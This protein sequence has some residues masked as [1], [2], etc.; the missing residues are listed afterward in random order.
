MDLGIV[1]AGK[2]R[3]LDARATFGVS[4]VVKAKDQAYQGICTDK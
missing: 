4:I 3:G 2:R 1:P